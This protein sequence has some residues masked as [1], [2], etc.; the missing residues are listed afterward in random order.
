M[1]STGLLPQ[2]SVNS[3]AVPPERY[4]LNLKRS[5]IDCVMCKKKNADLYTRPGTPCEN[6]HCFRGR[7]VCLSAQ[8]ESR[9]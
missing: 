7:L 3:L 8:F 1:T 9:L 6:W 2:T 4:V 5:L